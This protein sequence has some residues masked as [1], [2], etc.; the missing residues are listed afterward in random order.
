MTETNRKPTG[1]LFHYTT[2]ESALEHILPVRQ[3]RMGE[4]SKT[5][6]PRESKE[7]GTFTVT[8]HKKIDWTDA[9]DGLD[10]IK[11]VQNCARI[12]CLTQDCEGDL[13]S[14][15]VE[16][17]G[18]GLSRMWTQYAGGHTGVC[19]VFDTPSL[20][21]AIQATVPVPSD[22]LPGEVRYSD[23]SV[24]SGRA[25]V[26]AFNIDMN[27]IDQLGA[28]EAIRQHVQTNADTFFFKKAQ[29][30]RDEREYRWVYCA[31]PD[32]SEIHVPIEES[33][34]QV[35]LGVDFPQAFIPMVKDI[36][37]TIGARVTRMHMFRGH[38]EHS[39]D[40]N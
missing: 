28:A 39:D 25:K 31:R 24:E 37:Q 17:R 16:R 30:W 32:D 19:L 15:A 27:L 34:R 33:L 2:K 10:E 22:L 6:D 3:I 14:A 18:Y 20:Q 8:A 12:L 21:Q 35:V 7:W 4:Y 26:L 23:L 40:T 36:C 13:N 1:L 9:H 38:F 5:N 29:D 11:H